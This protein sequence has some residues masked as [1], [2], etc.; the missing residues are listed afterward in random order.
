MSQ[1]SPEQNQRLQRYFQDVLAEVDRQRAKW[2]P[3][4][5]LR[6][7]PGDWVALLNRQAVQLW[8]MT[9]TARDPYQVW[10]EVG[11]VAASGVIALLER[12]DSG[13]SS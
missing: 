10:V 3:Q 2:G 1:L 13:R 8:S 11:A 6:Y 4:S 9:P 5:D 12:I 7:G